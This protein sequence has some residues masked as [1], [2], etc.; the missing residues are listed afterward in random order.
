MWRLDLSRTGALNRAFRFG[1]AIREQIGQREIAI[2][3]RKI[4]IRRNS[5]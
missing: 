3:D 5:F 1:E 2:N 4:G